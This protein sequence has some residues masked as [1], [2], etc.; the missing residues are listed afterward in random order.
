MVTGLSGLVRFSKRLSFV[1]VISLTVMRTSSAQDATNLAATLAEKY[2]TLRALVVT[3]GNCAVF[4]YYRKNMNAEARSP[5]HSVTK[6]VLSILVGIAIDEGYLRLDEK[7]SEIVPE[8]FDEK[9]DPR[10]RDITVRDILTKTEGFAETSQGNFSIGPP[11]TELWRWMLNRR[12]NYPPGAHFRYDGVGS[13]LLAVVLSQA[14]KQDAAKFAQ[15]K[16]LGPLQISNYNWPSDVHG[17]LR[18]ETGLSLTARD[19][20]KI[21]LLY[22]RHGRWGKRQIVS[23]AYV[24]DST[25]RQNDGG[26]PA[27]TAYGYQWWVNKTKSDLDAFFAAGAGSQLVYVVPQLDLVAA[28]SAGGIPGGSQ[29]FVN[30]VV[31]SAEADFPASAPC[32]VE[33]GPH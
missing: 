18:G 33:L 32:I 24:T 9:V 6:S 28:V 21:G 16:L 25:T 30:N 22:L 7:L 8:A 12:I 2:P 4:E 31:V 29:T 13:D 3:R 20:A 27:K 10:V 26:P 11:G 17:Y 23:A 1:F 19:M 14:I 5:V 15:Q